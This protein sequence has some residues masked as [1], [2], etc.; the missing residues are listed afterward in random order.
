V[1]ETFGPSDVDIEVVLMML[2]GV[3]MLSRAT[4]IGVS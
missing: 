2:Q 1:V 4:L 3:H